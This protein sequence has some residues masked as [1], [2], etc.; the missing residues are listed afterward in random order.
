MGY[1][2]RNMPSQARTQKTLNDYEDVQNKV[3]VNTDEVEM[4][5]LV[6]NVLE[7]TKNL[8]SETSF[9]RDLM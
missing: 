6:E 8:L 1:H 9:T 3:R 2:T 5:P 7:E 4:M